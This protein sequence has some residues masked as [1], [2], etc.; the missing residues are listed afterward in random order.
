MPFGCTSQEVSIEC[1]ELGSGGLG[2]VKEVAPHDKEFTNV[3]N[4]I[5]LLNFPPHRLHQNRYSV[6]LSQFHSLSCPFETC[7]KV[8]NV[9]FRLRNP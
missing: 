5:I 3:S 6:N 7:G 2:S 9:T 4:L 1:T 8:A